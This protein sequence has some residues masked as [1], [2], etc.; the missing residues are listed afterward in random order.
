MFGV[1]ALLPSGSSL[2]FDQICCTEDNF[3]FGIVEVSGDDGGTWTELARYDQGDDPGWAD[4]VGD[5]TDYRHASLDLAA[6]ANQTVLVRF[7]LESDSN[8]E[9]DGWYLDNVHV[10]DAN[11]TP[12]VSVL[13]GNG[14]SQL[15]FARTSANPG[16]GAMRFAFALPQHEDRVDVVVYDVSGRELRHDRL[17]AKAPGEYSWTWTGRDDEGHAVASGVYF[18]RLVAGARTL[19]QKSIWLAE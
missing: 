1:P 5:P 2:E 9:F 16:R 4:G 12:V 18:A 14:P 6:F 8:L 17:G 11:C 7:R 15:R 10:N 13:P 19:T 3:D